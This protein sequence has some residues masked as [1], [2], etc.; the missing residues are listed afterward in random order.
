M[1]GIILTGGRGARLHP[2]SKIINKGLLPIYDKP[3]IYYPLC[4]LMLSGIKDILVISTPEDI[5]R[6]RDLLGDGS[7]LGI[8]ISYAIQENPNGIAEC[9]IIG[10]DFI[11]DDDVCLILGDNIFYGNHFGNIL[12]NTVE[13]LKRDKICTIFGYYVTDPERFGVVEFNDNMDVISLSEKPKKPRSNYAVVGLYFYD[14]SVVDISKNIKPSDRGELEITAVNQ[15]YLR[16]KKIKVKLLGRGHTWLDTG[17]HDTLVDASLFM[18][19][20]EQRQGLKVGCPEEVAFRMGFID[21]QTI[22][23]MSKK[24][25]NSYGD[26]LIKIINS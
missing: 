15:E 1:K 21:R 13:D 11:G 4:T 9:F 23:E 22:I 10:E 25:N 14:N 6:F 12:R 3:M 18:R 17:T 7:F 24:Y 16:N 8:S 19:L 20:M 26:Y 2:A 5:G